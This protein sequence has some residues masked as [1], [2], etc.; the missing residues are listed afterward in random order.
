MQHTLTIDNLANLPQV[1]QSFLAQTAPAKVIAFYGP[2]GVGKTTFIKEL[3]QLLG[4]EDV[5]NSPSFAIINEYRSQTDE[6]VYHFD[7]YR[8]K[9]IEEALNIGTEEYLYADQYCFIEWPEKIEELL[10]DNTLRV[11][12]SKDNQNS[13]ILQF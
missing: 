6:P 8:L 10:P 2:M 7:C 9:D 13:R 5:V 3:C 12:L 11:H 1:A 4:V